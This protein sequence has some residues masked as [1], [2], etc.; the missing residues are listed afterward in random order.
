MARLW[1]ETWMLQR[2]VERELA[3]FGDAACWLDYRLYLCRMYGF[4]APLE[5]ALGETPGL[6]GVVFDAGERIQKSSLLARDL[7][8]LGVERSHLGQIPR[9]AVPPLD[10]LPEA[11]G[12][13]YVAESVTLDGAELARHLEERLPAELDGAAAY[14]RCY[15]DDVAERW[16]DFGAAVDAY[17]ERAD[18]GAGVCAGDRIVLAATDCLFRFH[19][20]LAPSSSSI[21]HVRA[22]RVVA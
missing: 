6:A 8:S 10:E 11:L 22:G 19:R 1:A 13:M 3:G 7:L 4:L 20:W 2:R 21:S 5:A 18:A 14:L 9:I 17:V 12:W 16:R 15:G